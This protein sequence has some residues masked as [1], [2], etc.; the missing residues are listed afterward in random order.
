MK[1]YSMCGCTKDCSRVSEHYGLFITVLASMIHREEMGM[2][3]S[4][5][6]LRLNV[7]GQHKNVVWLDMS[8]DVPLDLLHWR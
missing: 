1:K 6:M 7:K 2:Y 5:E 3:I 4:E 8:S